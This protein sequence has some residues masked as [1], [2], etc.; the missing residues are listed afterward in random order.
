MELKGQAVPY[1]DY[2]EVAQN[3]RPHEMPMTAIGIY[4]ELA[5][6]R[7]FWFLVQLSAIVVLLAVVLLYFIGRLVTVR[8]GAWMV[9]KFESGVM[10]RV[11]LVS[12]VYSSVK[13]L[14]D[15]LQEEK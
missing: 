2:A 12:Q 15:F 5:K 14:T 7:Y 1:E 6:T 3:T 11:P 4:M 10:G 13:Q 8:V 9:Q